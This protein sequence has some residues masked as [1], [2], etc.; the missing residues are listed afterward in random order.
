MGNSDLRLRASVWRLGYG[1]VV[2]VVDAG[3]WTGI[4]ASDPTAP[5]DRRYRVTAGVNQVKLQ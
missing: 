3:P 4:A 2:L 1:A 5:A